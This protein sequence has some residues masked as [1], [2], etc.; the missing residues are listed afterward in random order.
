MKRTGSAWNRPSL[1]SW[2]CSAAWS[3][4]TASTPRGAG[5]GKHP[6]SLPAFPQLAGREINPLFL[7]E[8]LDISFSRHVL[9]PVFFVDGA[10]AQNLHASLVRIMWIFDSFPA[11]TKVTHNHRIAE[12][13][14]HVVQFPAQSTMRQSRLPRTLTS[15]VLNACK[16][17]GS[18]TLLGYL[19]QCSTTFTLKVFPKCFPAASWNSLIIPTW[20]SCFKWRCYSKLR[21]K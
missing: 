1:P 3:A 19:C 6:Q 14:N 12:V 2:T 4:F 17:G 18:T 20:F 9:L 7:L 21:K 15:W 8:N 13:Q 16:D 5:L 11:K 10:A